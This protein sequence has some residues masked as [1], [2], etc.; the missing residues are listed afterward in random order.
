MAALQFEGQR[1]LISRAA[2][3]SRRWH[4]AEHPGRPRLAL[5]S[6]HSELCGIASYARALEK[7]LSAAFDVTVFDLD[8]YL[9]RGT[10][11]RLRRLAD[12]H[13]RKICQEI[14]QFD[15]VNLQLEHGTLGRRDHDIYRRF[16]WIAQA[17]PRISVTFHT[18][19]PLEQPRLGRRVSR[20]LHRDGADEPTA[21]ESRPRSARHLRL[22]IGIPGRLRKLQNRKPVAAIVHNRRDALQMQY[23][24]R[25]RRVYHH[26]LSFLDGAEIEATTGAATRRQFGVLDSVPDQA[27]LIGVFGFYGE[28]KGFETVVRTMHHLPPDYHLLI[29][30]GVHPNEI[31][32]HQAIDPVVARLFDTAYIDTT[33]ADHLGRS[34]H[35]GAAGPVSLVFDGVAPDLLIRHPK[36]LSSRLHFLGPTSDADFLCGMAICDAVVFPYLEVGQ[37]ASGPISQAIELGCRVLA[38]RTHTFLQF[39]RYHPGRLEYFDIGNHLE[40]AGRLKSPP[41]AGH[42]EPLAWTVETNKAIYIAANSGGQGVGDLTDPPAG[43]QLAAGLNT[44]VQ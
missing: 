17:A 42:G 5:I 13:I 30:G 1:P 26:P 20:L 4:E 27:K 12:Q 6:V 43:E 9:L 23:V 36:D 21:P 19:F 37:S 14:R 8:Q 18:T 31:R 28:Y 22:A 3:A 2:A 16:S 32:P 33:V 7:Q 15:A 24:H 34:A 11:R 41:L 25:I 44:A 39:G 40:L 29:F 35:E 38:S 10:H